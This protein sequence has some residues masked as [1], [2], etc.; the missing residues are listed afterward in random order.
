MRPEAPALSNAPRLLLTAA[1]AAALC[2]I[3]TRSWW[4]W[5]ALGRIPAPVRIGR[6]VRWPAAELS[7]WVAAGCP[8]RAEWVALR[9]T[10]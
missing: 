10:H 6:S 4:T 1:E 3:S 5:D 9:K 7:A 2:G 8:R